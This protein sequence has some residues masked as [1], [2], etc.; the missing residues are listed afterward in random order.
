MP[1]QESFSDGNNRGKRYC[2]TEACGLDVKCVEKCYLYDNLHY[3]IT[4][5]VL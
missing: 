5:T 1:V 3:Y 4:E 2:V